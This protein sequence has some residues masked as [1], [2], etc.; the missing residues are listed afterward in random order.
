MK[1]W[2]EWAL[3][4]S[5]LILAVVLL[6]AA[7][8]KHIG[9][10]LRCALWVLVLM[11]L[12]VPV[13]LF[14]VPVW[15][16]ASKKPAGVQT[17]QTDVTL[18]AASQ[19]GEAAGNGQGRPDGIPAVTPASGGAPGDVSGAVSGG[20]QG[21]ASPELGAVWGL[22]WLGGA[23]V[24]GLILV[25]FNL[26]FALNIR[27]RRRAL[28]CEG[29]PLSVYILA[30]LPSPCLF[31]IFRPA[32]YVDPKAA[33]DPVMLRHVLAHEGTHFRHGD[34]IWSLLRCAALA[35]HWW[36]PL[37]WLA[38]VLSR[39]DGELFCDEGALKCLGDGERKAYGNTLLV[40]VTARPLPTDLLSCATTMSGGK[41]A[42]WERIERI[43]RPVKR[44]MWAAALAA[45]VAM[46]A[47]ACSFA[48]PVEKS[49]KPSDDTNPGVTGP[50][51][52]TDPAVPAVFPEGE[53]E[54]V[55]P[56]DGLEPY[57][58]PEAK[59]TGSFNGTV[60]ERVEIGGQVTALLENDKGER[61]AAVL[62]GDEWRV[63]MTGLGG[64]AGIS[65]FRDLF[66][67][68]GVCI[69]HMGHVSLSRIAMLYD[70][71]RVTGTGEAAPMLQAAME[72][73]QLVD[74]DG[75]GIDELVDGIGI[76]FLR[77][78]TLYRADIDALLNDG[79]APWDYQDHC[80][81]HD[82][83]MKITCYSSPSGDTSN[84][85]YMYTRLVC[86][87]GENLRV[88]KEEKPWHDHVIDGADEG[89][90][91]EV[92]D[93]ARAYVEGEVL[94]ENPDGT[95]SRADDSDRALFDD[96]R[97]ERVTFDWEQPK[98][99]GWTVEVYFFNY[100]LHTVTP[101]KVGIA[102]G[103]YVTEDDWVSPGYPGCDMLV[104]KYDGL[105]RTFL[106]HEMTNDLFPG[107]PEFQKHIDACLEELES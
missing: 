33:D 22:L 4:S 99:G 63:F 6:R 78:G 43:A 68:E 60:V 65:P 36:N 45:A 19:G 102:G 41:K 87:D 3:T 38:V 5:L 66:G 50:T 15:E 101:E 93:A 8:G 76:F 80:E 16:P 105:S 84:I 48:Q 54:R 11:R 23:I 28:A 73:P 32:V 7:V 31:G 96:W 9:A 100:E 29:C 49:N 69:S 83:C 27:R 89:I 21:G 44:R 35:I 58:P 95:F 61:A 37:V 98:D 25:M 103:M 40:L 72:E 62:V 30:G 42:L 64:E 13:Q 81:A 20:A 46:T 14:A 106:W 77:D 104:F 97:I 86:F 26:R 24:S 74:M 70:Y 52:P 47:A 67:C 71:F 94:A 39:R 88:Y 17:V 2:A 79:Q 107:V 85:P 59:N 10:G 1:F 34:H 53:P 55:V 57:T 82:R 12:L 51:Q 91:A 75:D 56:L 18:P 90:P 92:M